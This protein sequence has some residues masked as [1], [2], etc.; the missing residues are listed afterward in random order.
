MFLRARQ[1]HEAE[2]TAG[3][4]SEPASPTQRGVELEAGTFVGLESY[5]YRSHNR[6]MSGDKPVD[7]VDSVGAVRGKF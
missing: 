3:S 1:G 2:E 4:Y 7:A 6:F 5:S